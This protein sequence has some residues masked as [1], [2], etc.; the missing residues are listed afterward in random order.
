MQFRLRRVA[1]VGLFAAQISLELHERILKRHR[2][3]EDFRQ[4]AEL[5]AAW[6]LRH[7]PVDDRAQPA[8]DA[9]AGGARL[10]M[11][12]RRDALEGQVDDV[13]RQANDEYVQLVRR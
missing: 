7:A 2:R 5:A 10:T 11:N 3:T 8:D 12:R 6:S 9:G 1:D 4:G 13:G